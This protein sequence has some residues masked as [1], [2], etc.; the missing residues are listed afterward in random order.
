MNMPS[1]YISGYPDACA[2]DAQMASS[3]VAHTLL[4]DPAADELVAR[5]A[6]RRPEDSARLVGAAMNDPNDPALR[7]APSLLR[8]FFH[9]MEVTPAW[10]DQAEFMP[11]IRMFHRNSRLVL[12]AMVGGALVEGFT[13]N[14]SKSFFMTGRLRSQGLRRL[15]QNNRHMMEIF[16]PGGL[17]RFGDGWK[18]SVRIRLIHAQV[19]MLLRDAGEWDSGAWGVPISAAHLGFAL[20]A[21]S[22]RLLKH[23]KSLGGVFDDHER[24]SFMQ[25]WRYAGYLMG[26]PESILFSTE[27]DALKLF[28]V[29]TAC[30][31]PAG[32]ESVAMSHCLVN[33]APIFVGNTEPEERRKLAQYVYL[34][35]RSLIGKSLADQLRY[36][37]ASS[38][39]VLPWF[40]LQTRY[41]RVMARWFPRLAVHTN[42]T[43][44]IGLMEV[45]AYDEEGINYTLPQHAYAEQS[46][47]W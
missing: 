40:R 43:D 32:L 13:T 8:D 10:L 1:D 11:G 44:F 9:A 3:Y 4:G 37:P 25:V 22:A 42:L 36:P 45:S 31:P 18:L 14:I 30:E 29:G 39:G 17:E 21:F 2:I 26:I 5:L 6:S 23:L 27:A 34:V 33:S 12:A 16:L 38:F 7:A 19:R 15:Q 35:S 46:G 41:H 24:S 28:E 47:K 20:S